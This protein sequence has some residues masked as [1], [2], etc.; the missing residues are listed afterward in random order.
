MHTDARAGRPWKTSS[1]ARGLYV[2]AMLIVAF[3][4]L[5]P[6]YWT[7]AT[8]LKP[9]EMP[10]AIPPAW[11]FR[12]SLEHVRFAFGEGS[13]GM[14]RAFPNSLLIATT[15]TLL[16]VLIGGAAAY[17]LARFPIRGKKH[18]WFWIISNRMLTPVALALPFFLLGNSLGILD[19]RLILV[20]TYLTFNVPL[21]VWILVGF[22]QTIPSSLDE[23]AR[24]DGASQWAI[25]AR[26]AVPLALPG[27]AV[28]AIFTF[29]FAWNELM[30]ALVLT[31]ESARTMPV[32]TTAFIT[33]LGTRWG[34]MA[35][36]STVTVLP[37]M[38]LSLSVS[39]YIVR[40]LTLG[41]I[42]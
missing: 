25:F 27:V 9:G 37:I 3:F 40:G 30:F 24:I 7:V 8:A 34:P 21:V 14:Q 5:F 20:L 2:V 35:A 23:A 42:K 17:G 28:A 41:A 19:T 11:L 1:L 31:R 15:N 38:I 6:L 22:F 29:I 13:I 36:T 33:G 18:L 32:L 26:I 12:P 16:S 4:A 10:F 39:R